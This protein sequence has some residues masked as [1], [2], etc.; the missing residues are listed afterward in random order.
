V[1]ER[2]GR[3]GLSSASVEGVLSS[4]APYFA[5]IDADLTSSIMRRHC[6]KCSAA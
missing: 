2:I 6:R 5:V 1:I 4:A 3:R